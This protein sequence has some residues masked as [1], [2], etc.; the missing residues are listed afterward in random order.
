MKLEINGNENYTAIFVEI[1]TLLP[2]ENCDAIQHSIILGNYVIVG[3]DVNIGDKG[4]YFPVECKLSEDFLSNNNLY[5]HSEKN[6]DIGKKGFFEDNGRV[7]CVRMRGNKSEGFFIPLHSLSY[8]GVAEEDFKKV[9]INT[10]FNFVNGQQICEKYIVVGRNTLGLGL[11]NSK[12]SKIKELRIIDTYW[13]FHNDTAQFYKNLNKIS[14]DNIIDISYKLHGTSLCSGYIPIKRK[15][16]VVEKILKFFKIQIQELEYSYVWS[17]RKV[18]KN[19]EFNKNNK[20]YYD[21]DIWGMAFGKIKHALEKDMMIYAEIVGYLPSGK[22]IQ[23]KYDYGCS[24]NTFEVYVYRITYV[25]SQGVVFEFS[26][27]QVREYCKLYNLNH[28]PNFYYGIADNLYKNLCYKYKEN[29]IYSNE[30]DSE[31][32]LALLKKEY[33]DKDCFMCSNKVPEEGVVLR[34]DKNNAYESFKIKSI[35][36]YE[37]ETK[38]LDKEEIDIEES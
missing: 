22:E 6:K 18:I 14:K 20:H 11:K 12:K 32:F 2:L 23:S 16:S 25:N 36:F 17:S 4:I 38:L 26:P 29:L 8:L 28:V 15:L 24:L 3:K 5:R 1:K 19:S 27:Q 10:S 35:R 31:L 7:R 37:H 21:L 9:E 30:F 34:V 13:K 33:N